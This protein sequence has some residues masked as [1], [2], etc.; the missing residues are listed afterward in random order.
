VSCFGAA[1]DWRA[2]DLFHRCLA[3]L[4]STYFALIDDDTDETIIV[5]KPTFTLEGNRY[6]SRS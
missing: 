2:N 5:T 3:E 6:V 1:R 4:V